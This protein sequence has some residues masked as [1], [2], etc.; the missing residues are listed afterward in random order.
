MRALVVGAGLGG[1][2]AGLALRQA[3]A[4]VQVFER[5]P[6]LDAIAVG[7]GMVIWPN[8][9]CALRGLGL[10]PAGHRIDRLEFYAAGGRRLNAWDVGAIGGRMG[11]PSLA[12]SRG[13]L[14]RALAGVYGPQDIAF[15]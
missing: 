9:M 5:A 14:H 3:G 13:E 2:S 11:A 1:L 15:G 12:L 4:E 8:G 10:E 6:A 7:I